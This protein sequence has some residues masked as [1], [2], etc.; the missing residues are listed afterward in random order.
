[1][2]L[3]RGEV[4]ALRGYPLPVLVISGGMYNDQPAPRTVLAMPVVIGEA[5]D[6]WTAPIGDGELAVVDRMRPY[7]KR[8]FTQQHRRVDVQA[9][10]EV[11][12]L[13]F[14]ILATD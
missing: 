8:D 2:S 7:P 10:T 4:W 9:L 12:N 11:D 3:R 6:A 5:T 1:V 13:L 14:K